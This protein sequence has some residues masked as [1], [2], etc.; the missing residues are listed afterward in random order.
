MAASST[1][2]L[3]PADEGD[4]P[5]LIRLLR[6][7]WLV[8]WAPELPFEAV[9]AFASFDPARS[10]AETAWRDFTVAIRSDDGTLVG[11]V[12]TTDDVVDALHVDPACWNGGVGTRLLDAA[13]RRIARTHPVARLEVRHFNTRARTFYKR[14]G[15]VE[16]RRYA[17]TECGSPVENIE[18]RKILRT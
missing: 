13:E 9:Q 2:E 17:G 3:R 4:V 14:C 18:M 12:Q 11:M 15:W 10:H 16:I 8:A 6:R 5:A 7:S 1:I